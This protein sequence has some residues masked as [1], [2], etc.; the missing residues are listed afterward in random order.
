MDSGEKCRALISAVLDGVPAG[1]YPIHAGGSMNTGFIPVGVLEL[2]GTIN[3]GAATS[4]LAVP[5]RSFLASCLMT[6]ALALVAV[7]VC[8]RRSNE[9]GFWPTRR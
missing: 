6:L 8:R 9:S 3:V 4:G 1:S 2:E 7:G 5:T